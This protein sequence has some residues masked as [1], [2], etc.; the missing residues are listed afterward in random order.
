L[1][2][3]ILANVR[4]QENQA[5]SDERKRRC[6]EERVASGSNLIVARSFLERVERI[7]AGE[8]ADFSDSG[9]DAVVLT[10]ESVLDHDDVIKRGGGH[11][12][13]TS[14]TCLGSDKTDIIARAELSESK[15]DTIYH[16]E[17]RDVFGLVEPGVAARHDEA[18]NAL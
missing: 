16:H 13:D 1:I 7:G 9:R 15:E 17:T 3:R 11:V 14:R 5:R 12:P 8:S 2:N 6:H 18:D 4:E 10:T